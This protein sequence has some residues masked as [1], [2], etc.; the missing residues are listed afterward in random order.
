MEPKMQNRNKK[1]E[2]DV[3]SKIMRSDHL[4]RHKQIHRDLLSLPDNEIKNELE[5]RQ[6][7]K[8]IVY[9]N[10]IVISQFHCQ[11]MDDILDD[12]DDILDD[13]DDIE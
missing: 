9:Y 3:C 13:K 7:I 11:G 10:S 2:C 4:K 6:E 1:V 8:K 5:T 12:Q